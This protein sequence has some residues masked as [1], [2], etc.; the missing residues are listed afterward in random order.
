M[1]DD[2]R[3]GRSSRHFGIQ[4]KVVQESVNILWSIK[5]KQESNATFC[6][7]I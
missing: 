3:V 1:A 2:A 4:K 5:Y 6:A 7:G